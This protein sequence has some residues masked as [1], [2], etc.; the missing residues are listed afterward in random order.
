MADQTFTA[1]V[2]AG[3]TAV[4]TVRP[5][6]KLRTWVVTQVSVEMGTAPIGAACVLRKN[7]ALVTPLVATGD[8]ASGDPPVVL[9]GSDTMTITWTGCTPGDVGTVL[10]FYDEVSNR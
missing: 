2:A 8:A 5:S 3:G 6:Q 9:Y 4:V 7:G 10:M 1:V